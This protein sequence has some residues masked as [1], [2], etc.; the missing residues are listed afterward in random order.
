MVFPPFPSHRGGVPLTIY[1]KGF[2]LGFGVFVGVHDFVIFLNI[3]IGVRVLFSAI[4]G[5]TTDNQLL[6]H[7]HRSTQHSLAHTIPFINMCCIKL[8]Y[9]VPNRHAV[10]IQ[11][12]TPPR[13]HDNQIYL[14]VVVHAGVL[15]RIE[16]NFQLPHD[17]P[18]QRH[19]YVAF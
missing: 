6:K 1:P 9:T 7:L 18:N 3:I 14:K 8:L 11:Q 12:V 19:A 10:I 5:T 13:E 15:M 4:L 17:P 2:A 16:Y